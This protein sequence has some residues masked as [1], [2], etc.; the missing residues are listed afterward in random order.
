MTKPTYGCQ[1]TIQS[2]QEKQ[3]MKI[4]RREEKR[5]KKKGKG[6][7]DGDYFDPVMAF[8]PREM[9]AHRYIFYENITVF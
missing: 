7:D 6:T 8:N 5:E 1:V 2:E 4:Y 3:L 9:R